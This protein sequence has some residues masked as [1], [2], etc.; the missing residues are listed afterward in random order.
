MVSFSIKLLFILNQNE[1]VE[2]LA[3][4]SFYLSV[5]QFRDILRNIIKWKYN[6]GYWT[7]T[8]LF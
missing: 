7:S 2:G 3:N 1:I 5:K 8:E 4:V 6:E